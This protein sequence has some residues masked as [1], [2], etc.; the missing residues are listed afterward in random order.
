MPL[1]ISPSSLLF[2]RPSISPFKT[3]VPHDFYFSVSF[4]SFLFPFS[5]S[6]SPISAA[7]RV[8]RP[9]WARRLSPPASRVRRLFPADQ[10]HARAA[11]SPPV[12]R[13]G[14]PRLPCRSVARARRISLVGRP[15]QRCLSP[16]GRSPTHVTSPLPASHASFLPPG[17]ADAVQ[18]RR[19]PPPR[20]PWTSA[21]HLSRPSSSFVG[22]C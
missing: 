17:R 22:T 13:Q 6:L 5:L 7:A 21:L 19:P 1:Q 15:P 11:S 3:W 18:S 8:R 10:P 2:W 9:R 16:D 4:F 12:G 14:A 20:C